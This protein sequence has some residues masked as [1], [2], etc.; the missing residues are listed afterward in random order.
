MPEW[1]S[2]AQAKPDL[3]EVNPGTPTLGGVPLVS[4]NKEVLVQQMR[5]GVVSETTLPGVSRYGGFWWRVLA[6]IIDGIVTTAVFCTV[7][8]PL[9]MMFGVAAGAGEAGNAAGMMII[10]QVVQTLLQTL[11]GG[12][13]FVWMTGAYGGTL[14]KLAVGLRVVTADGGRITYARAFGRW[15]ADYLLGG[16]IY[17]LV[18][19]IPVGVVVLLGMTQFKD[20]LAGNEEALGGFGFAIAGAAIVGALVGAFPWWMAAFDSEKRALHD[21]VCATRVVHK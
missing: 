7:A 5:E 14:G 3:A 8:L 17:L 1:L 19:A 16:M 21:R 20:F 18:L 10:Q 13:Y 15:A 4:M 9:G 12:I 6:R 11:I 2:L